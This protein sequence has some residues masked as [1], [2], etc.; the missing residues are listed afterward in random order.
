MAND[1]DSD[2][3]YLPRDHPLEALVRSDQERAVIADAVHAK[4]AQ[5]EV[6]AAVKA[7]AE[8]AALMVEIEMKA[9]SK[10]LQSLEK[11]QRANAAG[12]QTAFFLMRGMFLE[13]NW[14]DIPTAKGY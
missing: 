5:A 4:Q 11:E 12:V 9:L 10:V 1:T 3:P 2:P 6:D 8:Q 7:Y 13:K 14:N